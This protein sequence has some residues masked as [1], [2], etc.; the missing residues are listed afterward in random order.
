MIEQANQQQIPQETFWTT[1]RRIARTRKGVAAI[2]TTI[3]GSLYAF[4]LTASY[5]QGKLDRD[6]Y[7][8]KLQVTGGVISAVWMVYMSGTAY[9]DGQKNSPP[10]AQQTTGPIVNAPA[11]TSV[12]AEDLHATPAETPNAK[13]D[14]AT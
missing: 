5:F 10:I 1:V 4:A 8:T 2:V 6:I 14:S 11:A 9:E 7:W 13:H 12:H 3:M